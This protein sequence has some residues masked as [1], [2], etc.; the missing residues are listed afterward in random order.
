MCE[1]GTGDW[2]SEGSL[3]ATTPKDLIGRQPATQS[4]PS[5][6]W[7][8]QRK[9]GGLGGTCRSGGRPDGKYYG[10]FL[11]IAQ[12]QKQGQHRRETF[13]LP[14]DWGGKYPF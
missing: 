8:G 14:V 5:V 12:M 11:A 10:V 13:I 4:Y 9:Q 2:H 7:T 1:G 6:I 3:P